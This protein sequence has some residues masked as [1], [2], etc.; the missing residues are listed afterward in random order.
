[1]RV[2]SSCTHQRAERQ[3]AKMVAIRPLTENIRASLIACDYR[4]AVF[5]QRPI[6]F[7][8]D[9]STS[10]REMWK[11]DEKRRKKWRGW[12]RALIGIRSVDANSKLFL[13]SCLWLSLSAILSLLFFHFFQLK[14]LLS[15]FFSTFFTFLLHRPHLIFSIIPLSLSFYSSTQN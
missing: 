11:E 13:I 3:S 1:M 14:A 8:K 10:P 12:G 9:L 5:S 7:D 6:C 2:N 15:V 4:S